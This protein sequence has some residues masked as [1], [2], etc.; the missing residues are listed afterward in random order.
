MAR[1]VEHLLGPVWPARDTAEP[2]DL[3]AVEAAVRSNM[4]QAGAAGLSRLLEF[5]APGCEETTPCRCGH[6]ARYLESRSKAVLT[7]VRK[8]EYVRPY[9]LGEHCHR[10]Q[11]PADIVLDVEDR[12]LSPGVRRRSAP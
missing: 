8:A 12:E 11:F 3:E 7:A 1:E 5:E 6:S 9:Y 10:G 4:H 2:V